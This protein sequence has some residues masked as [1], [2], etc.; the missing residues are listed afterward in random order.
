MRNFSL[1]G[2]LALLSSAVLAAEVAQPAR[3]SYEY[4]VWNVKRKTSSRRVKVDK[5]YAEL[6]AAERSPEGCTPCREDQDEVTLSNGL[7]FQACRKLAPAFQKALE[8]ALAGG[9]RIVTVV[10]YRAQMSRGE[11]DAHGDRTVLSNHAFG[12]ALDLNEEH[13]GLY[14]NCEAWSP[15]CRLR[16]DGPYKPG[17]DPLSFT[18]ESPV[19]K[20]LGEAGFH[21]GGRI[22]GRQKDFMHFSPSGY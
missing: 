17:V 8:L 3:C 4:S 19:V 10:G 16:K 6:T 9:Q 21:W 7:R 18:D 15:R 11:A 1:A 14:E 12:S 13:N 2:V 22:A 20:A 5:P